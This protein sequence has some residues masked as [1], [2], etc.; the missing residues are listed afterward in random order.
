MKFSATCGGDPKATDPDANRYVKLPPARAAH[1]TPAARALPAARAVPTSSAQQ[2]APDGGAPT[3][4]LNVVP[5]QGINA[6]NMVGN[7]LLSA[8]NVEP[9][10]ASSAST[11][12]FTS[13]T[14]PQNN[15]Q[16]LV[17][18]PCFSLLFS[19]LVRYLR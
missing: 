10:T 11:A 6:A 2:S 5:S 19:F 15:Q 17:S 9:T 3:V 16:V 18:P 1:T 14:F 12:N 7:A 4:T 13:A 8:L